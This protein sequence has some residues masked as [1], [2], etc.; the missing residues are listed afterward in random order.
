MKRYKCRGR[1]NASLAAHDKVAN[2]FFPR[3]RDHDTAANFGFRTPP[4]AFATWA[5]STA[6]RKGA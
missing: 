3:R 6:V 5:T 4:T 2:T 1:F